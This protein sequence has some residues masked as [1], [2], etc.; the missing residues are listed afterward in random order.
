VVRGVGRDL[1]LHYV[2]VEFVDSNIVTIESRSN[3]L[4][5]RDRIVV[6]PHGAGCLVTYDAVLRFLG[7]AGLFNPV[8]G[9]VFK[10]IGERALVG[11]RRELGEVAA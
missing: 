1:T 5:S 8:L 11:L 9:P 10:R 3:S 6:A 4:L 7:P 2:V